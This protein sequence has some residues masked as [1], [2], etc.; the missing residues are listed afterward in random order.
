MEGGGLQIKL[1]EAEPEEVILVTGDGEE[2][3][4]VP[5]APGLDEIREAAAVIEPGEILFTGPGAT[6]WVG[7]LTGAGLP[8]RILGDGPRRLL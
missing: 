5:N 6:S 3:Q 8:A 7:A 2:S 1:G 4:M